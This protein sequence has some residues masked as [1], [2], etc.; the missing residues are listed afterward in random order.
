MSEAKYK[1]G[2][3]VAVDGRQEPQTIE[4]VTHWY[5]MTG[6]D[7]LWREDALTPYVRPLAVGDRVRYTGNHGGGGIVRAIE[8]DEVCYLSDSA[9]GLIVRNIANLERI[10]DA[11]KAVGT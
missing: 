8:G 5:K 11:G 10:P 2:Q 9:R 1:V 7:Y 4:S 6:S 3:E